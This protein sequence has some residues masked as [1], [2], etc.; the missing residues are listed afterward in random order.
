MSCQSAPGMYSLACQNHCRCHYS[1]QPSNKKRP[2]PYCK[3]LRP[4]RPF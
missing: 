3:P 4:G 2:H 1:F